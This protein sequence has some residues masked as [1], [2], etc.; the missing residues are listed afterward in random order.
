MRKYI[1]LI[2]V[3]KFIFVFRSEAPGQPYYGNAI[4][5]KIEEKVIF[6]QGNTKNTRDICILIHILKKQISPS[7][8]DK[9]IL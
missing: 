7:P 3:V 2:C 1:I 5:T 6:M 8:L 4:F 9:L